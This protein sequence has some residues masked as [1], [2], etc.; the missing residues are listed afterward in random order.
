[1]TR[2][3][4]HEGLEQLNEEVL[5]MGSL[6][7]EAVDFATQAFLKGD[8]AL[9]NSVIAGDDDINELSLWIEGKCL[10]LQA[11]Q[12]PVAIDLRLL[13]TALLV[14]LH[15]E[16]IGDLA[17]NI[18]K[19]AKRMDRSEVAEPY[20]E[21]LRKMSAQALEVLRQGI[22]A[23]ADRDAGLA[24]SLAEIDQ[25]IDDMFKDILSRLLSHEKGES[26]E[27]PSTE[28]ATHIALAS[29]YIERMADQ[30]VDMG[31]RV[32]FLVTGQLDGKYFDRAAPDINKR[33]GE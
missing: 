17:V 23:Y 33:F 28:W 24:D 5:R 13:H 29:R 22:K 18:A 10:A 20:M 8:R 11:Q 9:A 16:R 31:G 7:V 27:A 21:I 3:S 2:Q 14:S 1:M 4:Y 6:V 32:S 30:V 25:P 19:I 26:G 12:Q 15:L